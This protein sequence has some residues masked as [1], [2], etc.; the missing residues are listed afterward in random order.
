MVLMS[1]MSLLATSHSWF[2]FQWIAAIRVVSFILMIL[3]NCIMWTTFTKALQY[4]TNS[5]EATVT[6][7]AANF[8]FTVMGISELL[9]I[10]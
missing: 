8:L 1:V 4:S 10:S 3:L 9:Y 5:V 6:N 2:V 7:T